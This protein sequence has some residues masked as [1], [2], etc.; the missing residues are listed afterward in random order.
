MNNYT[1]WL[2][3]VKAK[4]PR[5]QKQTK[6]DLPGIGNEIADALRNAGFDSVEKIRQASDEQLLAIS[7]IGKG[8][9]ETIRAALKEV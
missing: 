7:G 6:Q 8:R 1:E 9:L 2:P 5:P 4:K 3:G